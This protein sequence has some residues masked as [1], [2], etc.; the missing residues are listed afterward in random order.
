MKKEN[1]LQSANCKKFLAFMVIFTMILG[2]LGLIYYNP[3]WAGH[4]APTE[5]LSA[6]LN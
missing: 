2:F 6:A 4:E 3:A 5:T 1:M